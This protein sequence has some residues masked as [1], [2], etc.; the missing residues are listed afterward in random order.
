MVYTVFAP[1][2]VIQS[3]IKLLDSLQKL[4]ATIYSG[5]GTNLPM[6]PLSVFFYAINGKEE[7]KGDIVG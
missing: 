6:I 4:S 3:I 5:H 1:D 7:Y 2:P